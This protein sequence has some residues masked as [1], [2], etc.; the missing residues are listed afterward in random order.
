AQT[1]RQLL[2]ARAAGAT[3]FG[4]WERGVTLQT[5]LYVPGVEAFSGETVRRLDY[6][7][8]AGKKKSSETGDDFPTAIDRI[9]LADEEPTATAALETFLSRSQINAV[10]SQVAA[11]MLRRLAGGEMTAFPTTTDVDNCKYC[12]FIKVCT[13]IGTVLA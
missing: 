13:G 10:L 3:V 2:D 4:D 9:D 7:Y 5:I 1:V 11:E 8:L 12:G 6:I